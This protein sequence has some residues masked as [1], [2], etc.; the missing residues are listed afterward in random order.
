MR[1]RAIPLLLVLVLA[2]C[3]GGGKNA[4]TT[5]APPQTAATPTLT[6]VVDIAACNELEAKIQATSQLVSASVEVMTQ[7]VHPKQLAERAG[8][9]QKNIAYAA[10]VLSQIVVPAPV[11]AARAQL[12]S[13]LREYAAD[14]GRAQKAVRRNDIAKAAQE[15]ADQTALQKVK[16]A[17]TRIDR[18]CKPQQ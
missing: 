3:G 12:V 16:A 6:N 7:S 9:T 15:L 14:F 13:G 10:T 18:V 4:A 2:G 11:T 8:E 17:T 1:G 5:A